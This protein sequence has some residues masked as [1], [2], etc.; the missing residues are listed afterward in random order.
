MSRKTYVSIIDEEL[1]EHLKNQDIL[2]KTAL[3]LKKSV[4]QAEKKNCQ[5]IYLYRTLKIGVSMRKIDRNFTLLLLQE[6]AAKRKIMLKVFDKFNVL[7]KMLYM[8]S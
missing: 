4:L 8:L 1:L 5:I 2:D 7:V 6:V 3:L